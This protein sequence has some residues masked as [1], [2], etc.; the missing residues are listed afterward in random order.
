MIYYAGMY[1][2]NDII[3][4]LCGI[5]FRVDRE[6]LDL[7]VFLDGPWLGEMINYERMAGGNGYLGFMGFTRPF[8]CYYSSSCS[9]L[10]IS[11]RA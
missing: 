8:G 4:V 10:C 7:S 6:D 3:G 1:M 11:S 2:C 5:L 9:Y